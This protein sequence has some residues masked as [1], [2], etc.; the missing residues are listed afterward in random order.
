MYLRRFISQQSK[1]LS[2]DPNLT[3]MANPQILSPDT[4]YYFE[5]P[6]INNNQP[7]FNS[8]LGI[9][10]EILQVVNLL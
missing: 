7:M 5:C 2:C 10:D 3:N 9:R 4:P 1:R 8:N 6:N